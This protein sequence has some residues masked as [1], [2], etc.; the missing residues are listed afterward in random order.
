[1]SG[2]RGAARRRP[3]GAQR[4]VPRVAVP[5]CGAPSPR[6]MKRSIPWAHSAAGGD[7]NP[8]YAAGGSVGSAA[9]DHLCSFANG[10]IPVSRRSLDRRFN[11]RIVEDGQGDD[12][13][14]SD[15]GR[16]GSDEFEQRRERRVFTD[17]SECSDRRFS[18]RSV[19]VRRCEF[20]QPRHS[21]PVAKLPVRRRDSLDDTRIIIVTATHE[22]AVTPLTCTT[23]RLGSHRPD[24]TVFVFGN[25]SAEF[26]SRITVK[27]GSD[28]D[29]DGES[30]HGRISIEEERNRVVEE[31]NQRLAVGGSARIRSD[32]DP[33]SP[34]RR[35]PASV[36]SSRSVR[37]P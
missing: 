10:R 29:R 36:P 4:R 14:S 35:R 32:G 30:A 34:T 19:A 18:R 6:N 21:R 12:R 22:G 7:A 24:P 37:E 33:P 25:E 27:T 28:A 31:M 1:M 15:L 5:G 3:N 17:R 11:G 23:E 26:Y 13:S 9:D 2:R 16:S 8:G 20:D